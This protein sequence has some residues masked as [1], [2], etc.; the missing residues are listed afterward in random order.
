MG[1]LCSK[2]G[3]HTGGGYALG[4]QQA[5]NERPNPRIAAAQAAEQ[6]LKAVRMTTA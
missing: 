3:T 1:A 5:A 2:S 4:T 6:R